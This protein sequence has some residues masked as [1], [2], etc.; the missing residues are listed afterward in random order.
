[1]TAQLSRAVICLPVCS[2]VTRK[3]LAAAGEKAG[4]GMSCHAAVATGGDGAFRW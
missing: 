4:P 2:L 1:M 3:N